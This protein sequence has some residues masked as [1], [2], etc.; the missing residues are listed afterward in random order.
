[1]YITVSNTAAGSYII[2]NADINECDR[3]NSCHQ[4]CVNMLGSFTCDCED[5]Y[6]LLDD[7]YTCT[8]TFLTKLKVPINYISVCSTARER[9]DGMCLFGCCAV[10]A[11]EERCYCP[12]GLSLSNGNLCEG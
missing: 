5:G 10:I 6:T 12:V 1:M 4:V 11:G 9:C 7:D 2:V 8:R 3:V